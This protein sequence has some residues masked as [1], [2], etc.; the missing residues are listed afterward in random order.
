[1]IGWSKPKSLKD[2]LVSAKIKCE[3]SSDNKSA[4]CCR[5]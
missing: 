2:Q 5:S 3:P 1:M 4:R